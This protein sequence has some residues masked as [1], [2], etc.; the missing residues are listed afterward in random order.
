LT[1]IVQISTLNKAMYLVLHLGEILICTVA[2]Y[3]TFNKINSLVI[4]IYYNANTVTGV[5]V[6]E[7]TVVYVDLYL[8]E[9]SVD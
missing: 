1:S 9:S 3:S 5:Q 2:H 4:Y 7:V 6:Y 8:T